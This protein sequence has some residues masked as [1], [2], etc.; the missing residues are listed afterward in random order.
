MELR[1][2]V[3]Q[4]A[5]VMRAKVPATDIAKAL[6]TILPEIAGYL[7]DKGAAPLGPP[8]TRYI[9]MTDDEFELE[10]GIPVGG[11]LPGNGRVV[12][13]ELPG[14]RVVEAWHNGSYQSLGATYDEIERWI[15]AE[16]LTIAGPPWEVYV[17]DPGQTPNVADWRTQ[18]LWP[19]K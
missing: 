7:H 5:M 17:T 16:G 4:K 11:D 19:V 2:I 8:F 9:A 3:P 14:G 6:G 1:E 13:V 12:P 15:A 18:I 10:G